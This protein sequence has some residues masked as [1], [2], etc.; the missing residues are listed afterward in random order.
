MNNLLSYIISKTEV[1]HYWPPAHSSSS[2]E[3]LPPDALRTHVR[4]GATNLALN[5]IGMATQAL[6]DSVDAYVRPRIT[7]KLHAGGV[8]SAD[9]APFLRKLLRSLPYTP[10]HHADKTHPHG[11]CA[12]ARAAAATFMRDFSLRAGLTPFFVSMSKTEK[13]LGG[14]VRGSR[15]WYFAK[16]VEMP[17]DYDVGED[18][19]DHTALMCLVDVDYYIDMCAFLVSH[20]QPVLLYTFQPEVV[21]E[22]PQGNGCG[23]EVG[24]TF[25][26]DGRLEYTVCG[27]ATYRHFLWN[28]QVDHLIVRGGI[29]GLPVRTATYL[30]ERKQCGPHRNLVLLVPLQHWDGVDSML[31]F[32]LQGTPLEHLDCVCDERFLRLRTQRAGGATM[33][34]GSVGMYG[35]F[36][37]P[38]AVDSAIISCAAASKTRIEVP[39]MLSFLPDADATENMRMFAFIALPFYLAKVSSQAPYVFPLSEAVRVYDFD[40][41]RREPEGKIPLRAFM[42]PFYNGAFAPR[43][44]RS[45]ENMAITKRI[46]DVRSTKCITPM[47]ATIIDEFVQFFL[48]GSAGTLIPVE[49]ERV[50]ECQ[51]RPSQ[52]ANLERSLV[53]EVD[54][55]KVLHTFMKREA[56]GDINDPRIISPLRPALKREYS[57]FIYALALIVKQKSWYAF[58]KTPREVAERVAEQARRARSHLVL[59]DFSRFDGTVSP[60]LR[61]LEEVTLCT[62]FR[63]EYIQE[64]T[65][66]HMGQ[67][68]RRAV[69][70][71][72]VKYDTGFARLS[73]S[74]ETSIFNTIINAFVAY[75]ALRKTRQVGEFF[76]PKEAHG[77]LGI[78]GGDDGI[79]C[80][81]DVETY[82]HVAEELGLRLTAEPIMRNDVRGNHVKFLAR[83]YSPEIWHGCVDSCCDITRQL[84][85][86][87]TTPVMDMSVSASDKL[88]EKARSFLLTDPNTPIIGDFCRRV[89]AVP[90]VDK[91][92]H[93]LNLTRANRAIA[94]MLRWN[95]ELDRDVQYPNENV[96]GWMNAYVREEY[97]HE[98]IISDYLNT[99]PTDAPPQEQY[100]ALMRVPLAR[101]FAPP[102]NAKKLPVIFEDTN[103]IPHLRAAPD[104]K[105]QAPPQDEERKSSWQGRPK[106]ELGIK[107]SQSKPPLPLPRPSAP[108][109]IPLISLALPS[110]SAPIRSAP[111]LS[112]DSARPKPKTWQRK[113]TAQETVHAAAH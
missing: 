56:Y 84:S 31:S 65:E 26:S 47:W 40:I 82:T 25:T 36:T 112:H 93:V 44:N 23:S 18:M 70:S 104:E 29:G 75:A 69:G 99:I 21:S 64:I 24:F 8:R 42:S 7:A 77:R 5:A 58:S 61:V 92:A 34:T 48:Q 52:R 45:A 88:C 1:G 14:N 67:Y 72:G 76:T 32:A 53:M 80:D 13:K 110:K 101:D 60:I 107:P 71:F 68:N 12:S 43:L 106:R 35:S 83:V 66:H 27:G 90:D 87:H 78:Y 49:I 28:Y 20:R 108:G 79:T 41:K 3:P 94:P 103:W 62:A 85:K 55:R 96:A 9:R 51:V 39:T 74:P 102:V 30:V 86:F 38:V 2:A 22:A 98:D 10:S 63:S 105:K 50:Y 59:S 16:D 4:S 11:F 19:E 109:H 91:R 37:V 46:T 100:D 6:Y 111:S 54:E 113:P 33:S 73:G 15:A 17:P 95:S 57:R 89:A 81:I 97:F